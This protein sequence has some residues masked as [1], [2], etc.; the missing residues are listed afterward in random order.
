VGGASIISSSVSKPFV[1]RYLSNGNIDTTFN[2]NGIRLLWITNLDYQYLF[3]VEDL[4]VQSN[5]KIS[6]VGWR[7]FPGLSW[8]SDYWACRINSDGAMDVTFSSDG[9]N[10]FN[11]N[12]NG[13]DRAMQCC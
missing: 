11:G 12:Y 1:A 2:N 6:V 10:V 5:G 8:D 13:H 4:A 7:D 9:V 3:S